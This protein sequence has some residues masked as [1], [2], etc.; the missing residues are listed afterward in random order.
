M[1]ETK[2]G[3]EEIGTLPRVLR[4]VLRSP[5]F[6]EILKLHLTDIDPNTARDAIKVL[7]WE[8]V[9]FALSLFD[10]SPQVLNSVLGAVLELGIQLQNFSPELLRSY[11][12][13]MSG[14][15]DTD[16]FREIPSVY[17]S[18]IETLFW[19]N[20]ELKKKISE[21]IFTGVNNFLAAGAGVMTRMDETALEGVASPGGTA[22]DPEAVG[23]FVTAG[24]RL[25][26]HAAEKNPYFLGDVARNIE[27]DELVAA[28]FSILKGMLRAM[29]S[30]MKSLISSILD[31]ARGNR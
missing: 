16:S 22:L 18:L 21:G 20:P 23:K 2:H 14:E 26:H 4:E 1:D 31:R 12:N 7:M 9:D 25:L 28:A 13:H 5:F 29:A 3:L 17:S 8:D 27:V 11:V 15:I 10:A 24:A 19:E 6:K 30:M